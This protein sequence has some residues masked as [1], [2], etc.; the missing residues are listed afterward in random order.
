MPEILIV[1]GKE[2]IREFV[3][4]QE[5]LDALDTANMPIGSWFDVRTATSSVIKV[6]NG[7]QWL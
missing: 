5:E 7:T 6:W 1:N 4:T 2:Q 3:G